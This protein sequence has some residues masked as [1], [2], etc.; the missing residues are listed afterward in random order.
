MARIC[1]NGKNSM[2]CYKE[3]YLFKSK[4]ALERTI[5]ISKMDLRIHVTIA[6][7]RWSYIL[8]CQLKIARLEEGWER[9]ETM[10]IFK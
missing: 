10:I 6:M 1:K 2:V 3:C 4:N 7:A 5:D 9:F 8:R